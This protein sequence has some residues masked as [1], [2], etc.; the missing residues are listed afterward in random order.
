VGRYALKLITSY[1]VTS[2]IAVGV[3]MV[4]AIV[5][6]PGSGVTG[7]KLASVADIAQKQSLID[8]LVSLIPVN[9]FEALSTGN[10]LQTIFSAALIGVGIQL[11]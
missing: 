9:L 3:G 2:A 1:V 10:L 6:Q 4:L 7:F 11:V 8:W 5:L